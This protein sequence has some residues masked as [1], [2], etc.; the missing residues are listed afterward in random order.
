LLSPGETVVVSSV[1][2]ETREI[3]YTNQIVLNIQM[4]E[5]TTQ[6]QDVVVTALGITRK[7]RSLGYSASTIQGEQLT[8]AVSANWTD[9]LSGKVAGLN[10][11]RSGSGPTGSNK[12][13]LRGENNLTGENEALIVVDGVVINQGSGRR[14]AQAGETVYGVREVITC[15]PITEAV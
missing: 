6:L 7:E 11:I 8:D 4:T 12:I 13:I 1:G 5:T 9:A 14:T 10:M 3:K 15:L 2:F